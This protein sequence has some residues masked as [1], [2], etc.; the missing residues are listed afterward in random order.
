[1]DANLVKRKKT[2]ITSSMIEAGVAA[3]IAAGYVEAGEPSEL[4]KEA[5]QEI[6]LAMLS[7]SR[8]DGVHEYS[9]PKSD[10]K[11]R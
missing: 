1:M 2:E 11:G 3:L 5:V 7:Q 4:R 6:Y 10:T 9:K 8:A